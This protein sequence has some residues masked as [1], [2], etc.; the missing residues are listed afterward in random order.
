MAIVVHT[1]DH[2]E[3]AHGP[4]LADLPDDGLVDHDVDT[5]VVDHVF[6]QRVQREVTDLGAH[7]N[8]IHGCQ[9]GDGK[10]VPKVIQIGPKLDKSVTFSDEILV[11]FGNVLKTDLKK[12]HIYPIW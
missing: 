4:L 7:G 6:V 3:R 12:S 1:H 8:V 5:D 11:H 2:L 10:F 9:S